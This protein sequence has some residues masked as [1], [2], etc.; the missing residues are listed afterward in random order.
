M[1]LITQAVFLWGIKFFHL[2]EKN[3]FVLH[4]T[5]NQHTKRLEDLGDNGFFLWNNLESIALSVEYK[6][7]GNIGQGK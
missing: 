1:N 5:F 4:R 6:F 2:V 7:L 3:Q